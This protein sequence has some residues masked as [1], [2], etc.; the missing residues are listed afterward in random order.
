M[1]TN[2]SVNAADLSL[3]YEYQLM[4]R[5]GFSG[6]PGGGAT[7]IYAPVAVGFDNITESFERSTLSVGIYF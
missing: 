3:N 5:T 7:E 1:N 2:G 4:V 6:G